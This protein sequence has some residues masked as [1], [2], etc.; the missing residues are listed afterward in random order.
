MPPKSQRRKSTPA[1]APAKAVPPEVTLENEVTPKKTTRSSPAKATAAASSS[2][3]TKSTAPLK[4]QWNDDQRAYVV[5]WM[6]DNR[7][8]Y[9]RKGNVFAKQKYQKILDWIP[10]DIFEPEWRDKLS[11]KN[12]E[13]CC[14]YLESEYK[15]ADA[16]MKTTG[17]GLT[18]QDLDKGY[19]NLHGIS[20][21]VNV[22]TS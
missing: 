5:Q 12:I 11:I 1:K 21:L 2:P 20:L 15:A 18:Q 19:R 16:L 13:T 10:R 7:E 8:L 9:I 3:T 6:M 17:Q 22:L 4:M 14:R